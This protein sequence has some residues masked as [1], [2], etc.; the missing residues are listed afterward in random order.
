MTKICKQEQVTFSAKEMYSLVNDIES[1]PEFLPWCTATHVEED[2]GNSLIASMSISIGKIKQTFTT[3]NTMKPT[4]S[5]SMRLIEGPFKELNGHWQFKDDHHGGCSISLDMK[6]EFKNK[7]MKHML[8]TAFQKIID[9]L[10]D[11]FIERA[12]VVYGSE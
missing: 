11:A 7:I 10:V 8:G 2:N 5:I 12:R 4:E 9:S 3:A 6:F 1:Y